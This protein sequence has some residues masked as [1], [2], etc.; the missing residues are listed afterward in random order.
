L[1]LQGYQPL[2]N[3]PEDSC[4]GPYQDATGVWVSCPIQCP[5][6]AGSS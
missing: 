3:H 4:E 5:L 6:P 1:Y 2:Q